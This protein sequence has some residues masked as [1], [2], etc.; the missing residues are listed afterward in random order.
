MHPKLIKNMYYFS[1][2]ITFYYPFMLMDYNKK[3]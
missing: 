3:I 2:E 1:L